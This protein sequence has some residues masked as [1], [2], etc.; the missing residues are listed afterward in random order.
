MSWFFSGPVCFLIF[1]PLKSLLYGRSDSEINGSSNSAFKAI[2]AINA[3]GPPS[4]MEKG[5]TWKNFN[6]VQL[7]TKWGRDAPAAN[8]QLV[9]GLILLASGFAAFC[10]SFISPPLLLLAKRSH[11]DEGEL[12]GMGADE[13]VGEQQNIGQ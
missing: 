6:S 2:E 10:Y 9:S 3:F 13:E 1:P 8:C 12:K 4:P 7:P 5:S 11:S